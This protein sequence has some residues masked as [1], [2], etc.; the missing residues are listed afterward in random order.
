MSSSMVR[1]ST[2]FLL[3]AVVE[4]VHGTTKI[5]L[6]LSSNPIVRSPL[7]VPIK[8]IHDVL[9]L[10]FKGSTWV[11]QQPLWLAKIRTI[12]DKDLHSM[13]KRINVVVSVACRKV[14]KVGDE[15]SVPFTSKQRD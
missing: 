4:V 10:G 3:F 15:L 14:G 11:V 8:I 13:H 5:V 7:I 1:A 6:Y 9:T 12:G 2:T